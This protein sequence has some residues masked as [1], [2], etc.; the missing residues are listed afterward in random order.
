MERWEQYE[1]WAPASG[2]SRWQFVAAFHDF[3][4]ASA[5]AKKRGTHVRLIQAKYVDGKLAEQQVILDLG[6]TRQTA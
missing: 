5:V 3:D 6:K 4:I 2:E 1:I